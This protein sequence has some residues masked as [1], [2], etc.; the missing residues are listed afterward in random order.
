[1]I[2]TFALRDF[3]GHRNTEL[4]LGRFT[5]LVGDNASGKTTVLDALALQARIVE[6]PAA[7][8]R[9][10]P[11]DDLVRRGA[12]GVVVLRTDGLRE[13]DRALVMV[14]VSRRRDL[15]AA[16]ASK[17]IDNGLAWVRIKT[18]ASTGIVLLRSAT[19]RPER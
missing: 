17:R 10:T 18:F 6:D 1:M 8:L 5:M 16:G 7:V 3:K 14:R 9:D 4:E 15:H 2:S 19:G 11:F 12:G 13:R